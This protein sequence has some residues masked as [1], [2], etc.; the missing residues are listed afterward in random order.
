MVLF[1]NPLRRQGRSSVAHVTF[2]DR[3]DQVCTQN[4]SLGSHKD[5]QKKRK[6][7]GSDRI[8]PIHIERLQKSH[9]AASS[10]LW[11]LFFFTS[12]SPS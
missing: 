2:L 6:T 8:G 7:S 10:L 11:L 1:N 5:T 4:L 3:S 9:P 12:V